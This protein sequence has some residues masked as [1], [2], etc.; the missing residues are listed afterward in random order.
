M[1]IEAC[2][3]IMFLGAMFGLGWFVGDKIGNIE[4]KTFN[5]FMRYVGVTLLWFVIWNGTHFSSSFWSGLVNVMCFLAWITSM[6]IIA[7]RE[8]KSK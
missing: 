7:I 1:I 3:W 6:S 8:Y 4:N 5:A 2:L